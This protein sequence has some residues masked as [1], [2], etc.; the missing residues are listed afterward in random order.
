MTEFTGQHDWRDVLIKAA[1]LV[2]QG[3]CQGH[4][5]LN[6]DG[7]PFSFGLDFE[8]RPDKVCLEGALRVAALDLTGNLGGMLSMRAHQKMADLVYEFPYEW[9][10]AEG[11]TA[12]EVADALRRAA[13]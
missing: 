1:S 9:N 7:E 10:D 13:E 4:L 2:E 6:D 12:D 5:Y 8:R 3:W 11:R